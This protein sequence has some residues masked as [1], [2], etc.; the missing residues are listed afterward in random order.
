MRQVGVDFTD[1]YLGLDT[2]FVHLFVDL[3]RKPSDVITG[4]INGRRRYYMDAIRYLLLALFLTGKY[5][6]IIHSSGVLD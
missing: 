3:F 4:Y 2:K 5:I 6:F 1:I